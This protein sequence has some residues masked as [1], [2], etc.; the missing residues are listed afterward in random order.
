MAATPNASHYTEVCVTFLSDDINSI[1]QQGMILSRVC[2]ILNP[3][4]EKYQILNEDYRILPV[5]MERNFYFAT[6]HT[7][8]L[9]EKERGLDVKTLF[10]S[11]QSGRAFQKELGHGAPNILRANS[12]ELLGPRNQLDEPM[13]GFFKEFIKEEYVL[14]LSY[15]LVLEMRSVTYNDSEIIALRSYMPKRRWRLTTEVSWSS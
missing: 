15:E 5:S 10:D 8:P 2:E 9:E 11:L 1:G 14:P 3:F 6:C 12:Y 4:L 7:S 13:M